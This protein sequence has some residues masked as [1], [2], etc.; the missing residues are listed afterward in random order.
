VI[1]GI[2]SSRDSARDLL[3][4]RAR[5]SQSLSVLHSVND[6]Y[7][8]S[9]IE[10]CWLSYKVEEIFGVVETAAKI[11]ELVDVDRVK[12]LSDYD[13]TCSSEIAHIEGQLNNLSSEVSKLNVKEEEIL[14]EEERIHKK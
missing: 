10:I 6:F 9:T 5:V 12:A 4:S 13:L 1:I 11:E 8:L 14:R 3:A 7:K 2:M